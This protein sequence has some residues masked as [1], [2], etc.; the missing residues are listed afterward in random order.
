VS[1]ERGKTNDIIDWVANEGLG[2]NPIRN[3]SHNIGG[4]WNPGKGDNPNYRPKIAYKL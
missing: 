1:Q 4:D 2:W 3:M